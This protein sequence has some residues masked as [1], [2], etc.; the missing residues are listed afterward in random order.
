MKYATTVGARTYIIEINRD[1]EVVV[2]GEWHWADLRSIDGMGT[3]SLLLDTDSFEALVEARDGEFGVLLRGRF[4]PVQIEDERALR[5]AQAARGQ[6]AP[7]GEV[8]IKS[9]MPGLIVAVKVVPGQAVRKGET[10]V[11]LESMKMENELKA[12]RDGKVGAVRV[13]PRQPVE[14][15][16]TLV[17]IE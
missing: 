1:G 15:G 9:P 16:Q 10:L 12:P 14:Q 8:A 7:S 4:Y 5:L 11:I 6:A 17:T 2:D 13:E 3:F